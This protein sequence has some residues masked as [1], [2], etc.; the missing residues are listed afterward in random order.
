MSKDLSEP[1]GRFIKTKLCTQGGSVREGGYEA[2]SGTI[3]DK[4]G[5]CEKAVGQMTKFE[6]LSPE[7]RELTV[8]MY[9][10]VRKQNGAVP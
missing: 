6:E 1:L 5:F 4:L 8:K 3:K 7:A 9:E 10:F 2:P